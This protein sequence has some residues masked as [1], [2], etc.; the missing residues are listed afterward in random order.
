MSDYSY[1]AYTRHDLEEYKTYKK[2][3]KYKRKYKAL[4]GAEKIGNDLKYLQD[5]VS[6]ETGLVSDITDVIKSILGDTWNDKKFDMGAN[7]IL[8][9]RKDSLIKALRDIDKPDSKTIEQIKRL[10]EYLTKPNSCKKEE[11]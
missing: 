2:Y 8:K 4:G 11:E 1:P 7:I 5:Q 10:V 3:K 6:S 9:L